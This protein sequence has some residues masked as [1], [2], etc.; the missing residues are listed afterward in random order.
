M[1]VFWLLAALMTVI[2][3][4][5]VLVPMLRGRSPASPSTLEANLAVLRGQRR[6]IEADVANG[7]LPAS[8]RE[9]ALAELVERARDDLASQEKALAPARRPW[10]AAASLAV[11][12]PAIA[13]GI[14]AWLGAPGSLAMPEASHETAQHLDDAQIAAMVDN[15]ARKVRQ[16][17]DDARGWAL[18]ARSYAALGRFDDSADAYRH[19]SELVPDDPSVLADYADAL[20]MAQGRSLAGKPTELVKKAL[21]IDPHHRKSL[22]LAGTAAMD[23]GDF[24]GAL[25]YWQALAVQLEPG[26]SDEQEMTALLD[27]LRQKA[28]AAG[29]PLPPASAVARA[30]PPPRLAAAPTA[31]AAAGAQKPL[32]GSVSLAP[33]LASKMSPSDTLFVYARAENGPRMPL[34]VVRSSASALPMKFAMDD[35]MAMAPIARLSTATAVRIEAR[36]SR[37]GNAIP[38]PG[39]LIGTSGVVKPDAHDVNVVIDK[40]VP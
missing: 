26:S 35:S 5:I 9:E 24:S 34:A 29:K 1:V 15:L 8:E 11:V 12:L 31:P 3:L 6:E 28:A 23:A 36:I 33:A 27:E 37:S 10:I 13:F 16:R 32:T 4:A 2:A 21:S 18:L 20:G 38:Q 30:S 19:L 14:Y 7:L 17:P 40:V 25:Q 39:D 22:A